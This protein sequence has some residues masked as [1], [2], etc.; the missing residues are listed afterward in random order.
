MQSALPP[1]PNAYV[2]IQPDGKAVIMARHVEMGRWVISWNAHYRTAPQTLLGRFGPSRT[3]KTRQRWDNQESAMIG[4][5]RTLLM[6]SAATL[7]VMSALSTH[8]IAQAP[9]RSI[10]NNESVFID[11]KAL[12]ITQGTAKDEVAS[13]ITRLG[14][15]DLGP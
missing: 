5:Q 9:P 4:I 10:G 8:A 13:K 7:G 11:G 1:S 6:V 15:R 2:N 12:T 14:A 3:F